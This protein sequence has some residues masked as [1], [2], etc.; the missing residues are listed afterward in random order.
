MYLRIYKDK[1]YGFILDDNKK[2]SDIKI[3]VE[4]YNLYFSSNKSYRIKE[5]LNYEQGL[6]GCLEEYTPEI[7]TTPAQ[8]EI[9]NANLIKQNAELKAEAEKQKALNSQI[10]LELARLKQGGED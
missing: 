5:N 2:E 1:K 6:F 10:L 8:Q 3:S 9:L 7:K 4:D